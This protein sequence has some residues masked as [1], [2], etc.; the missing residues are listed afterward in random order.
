[1]SSDYYNR[2]KKKKVE[3]ILLKMREYGLTIDD[4]REY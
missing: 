2:E 4:L 3:E 1:M